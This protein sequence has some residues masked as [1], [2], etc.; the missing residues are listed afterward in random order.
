MG[1]QYVNAAATKWYQDMIKCP[2]NFPFS[3]TY[4]EKQYNGFDSEELVLVN[5]KPGLQ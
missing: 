4:G 3:F 5:K 2:E 1:T